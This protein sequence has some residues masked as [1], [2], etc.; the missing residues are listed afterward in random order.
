MNLAVFFGH[1]ISETKHGAARK[2]LTHSPVFA[3]LPAGDCV[4]GAAPEIYA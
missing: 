2:G 3:E 1:K 4:A